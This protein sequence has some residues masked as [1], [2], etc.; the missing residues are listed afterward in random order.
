MFWGTGGTV[1]LKM[2]ITKECHRK[3][4]GPTEL[5]TNNQKNTLKVTLYMEIYRDWKKMHLVQEP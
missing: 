1:F 4:M 3:D 5:S 2:D